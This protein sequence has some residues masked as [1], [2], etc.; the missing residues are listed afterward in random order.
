MSLKEIKRFYEGMCH[1]FNYLAYTMPKNGQLYSSLEAFVN[2]EIY[3]I[4]YYLASIRDS[5]EQKEEVKK[6][7]DAISVHTSPH[8]NLMR[9]FKELLQVWITS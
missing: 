6:Q 3:D 7:I 5:E 1:A 8:P 4:V 2:T 9:E